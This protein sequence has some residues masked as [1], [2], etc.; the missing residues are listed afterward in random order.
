MKK[1][2]RSVRFAESTKGAT[3][4]ISKYPVQYENVDKPDGD[5]HQSSLL[6]DPT[7]NT[8]VS[9][10]NLH[11]EL[12]DGVQLGEDGIFPKQLRSLTDNDGHSEGSS[13]D[14][15]Q[16]IPS[17]H[18]RRSRNLN[19]EKKTTEHDG[20]DNGDSDEGIEKFVKILPENGDN[21]VQGDKGRR[22]QIDG[23]S[24][25]SRNKRDE[26]HKDFILPAS[27][28]VEDEKSN[29]GGKLL[30]RNT[31]TK[32][33]S[34]H[35]LAEDNVGTLLRE[36]QAGETLAQTLERI[37]HSDQVENDMKYDLIVDACVCLRSHYE[38]DLQEADRDTILKIAPKWELCWG[39]QP[40]G[41]QFGPFHVDAFSTWARA[42][43][44]VQTKIAW[45]RPVGG[46]K[47]WR[48]ADI[49]RL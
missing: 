42:R 33:R 24:L 15:M 45:V 36:V 38:G 47:W 34:T 37:R 49:F 18:L 12:T 40:S 23:E 9:P 26:I 21:W 22:V 6:N 43:Y 16:G 19:F 31:R 32:Y 14:D 39:D 35:M 20:S 8:S 25:Q 28:I 29:C 41:D 13:S 46:S 27:E 2:K 1:R 10:F 7:Y 30:P 3:D 11:E 5:E 4:E 17:Q 48:A 44:F